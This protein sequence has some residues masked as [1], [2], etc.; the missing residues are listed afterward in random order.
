MRK[1]LFY[2]ILI[3]LLVAS[4]QVVQAE[5]EYVDLDPYTKMDIEWELIREKKHKGLGDAI[6]REWNTMR[7]NM[8][9]NQIN[10]EQ[11]WNTLR[12]SVVDGTFINRAA[13]YQRDDETRGSDIF[14][15]S[16]Y[17]ATEQIPVTYRSVT[18]RGD[19]V[20][21]SGKIFVPKIKKALNIVIASHYTICS[22]IEAPSNACSLEGIFATKG[23]I[24]L[25]PDYVGYGISDSIT[26]PYLHT[27]S[28]VRSAIDLLEAAIPYLR[29][30][31]YTF[32]PSLILIGYSQGGAATLALQRTLES[33]YAD[34]YQVEQVY[35]GAGPYDLAGT[36]EYYISKP[37][38]DIPCALPMIIIGMDY[39]ENLGFKREDFFQPFM[40]RNCKALIEDKKMPMNLVN[41]IL[42]NDIEYILK[43][44]IFQKD[45]F[46]TSVLYQALKKN[47]VM[48]WTPK[49]PL[50][51]FHST[52][53]NM[54]PFLNSERLSEQFKAK[55]LGNIE[56]DFD[57]YGNHMNGAVT[58][59]EKVYRMLL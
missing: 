8:Y 50:Y 41:E 53:D 44:V 7:S 40:L 51:M 46:P 3:V 29:Y 19:S 20:T 42:G 6:S 59:F 27:E 36:Y 2:S 31:E 48:D 22:D 54:V 39:G 17:A 57:A 21:L 58:F 25:M 16:V 4:A 13:N 38:I 55:K 45:S 49:A 37:T 10:S 5:V 12:L 14:L 11:F 56:Y 30:H 47:S 23:Y 24:V 15:K 35:A 52:E 34:K 18:P 32:D 26:H 28:T 43:P 33:E 1:N 9:E